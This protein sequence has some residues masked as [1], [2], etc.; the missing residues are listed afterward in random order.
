[1]GTKNAYMH[2]NFSK[3]DSLEFSNMKAELYLQ[4]VYEPSC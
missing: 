4:E 2:L 1:M 3:D